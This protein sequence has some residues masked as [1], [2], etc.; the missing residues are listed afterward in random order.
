MSFK[1]RIFALSEALIICFYVMFLRSFYNEG[2]KIIEIPYFI[3]S[4]ACILYAVFAKDVYTIKYA[5][6]FIFGIAI[7]PF[8]YYVPVIWKDIFKKRFSSLFFLLGGSL[9][10]IFSALM[11]FLNFNNP[12]L[13]II[14]ATVLALSF[15]F[16]ILVHYVFTYHELLESK[17]IL[18]SKAL[19]NNLIVDEKNV[20]Y[21][22]VDNKLQALEEMLLNTRKMC[23]SVQNSLTDN[24]YGTAAGLKYD[25]KTRSL[26]YASGDKLVIESIGTNALR[27]III[28][29]PGDEITSAMCN[30]IYEKEIGKTSKIKSPSKVLDKLNKAFSGYGISTLFSLI[31]ADIFPDEKL[32]KYSGAG[33]PDILVIRDGNALELSTDG[34]PIGLDDERYQESEFVLTA[35]DEVI[36]YTDG[37]MHQARKEKNMP[38][39]SYISGTDALGIYNSLVEFAAQEDEKILDDILILKVDI[40]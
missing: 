40:L 13:N 2:A 15:S 37:I 5:E 10:F 20:V 21:F 17:Y 11:F 7:A 14:P 18:E 31:V 22:E 39:K 29:Y 8:S 30:L 33:F 26:K 24:N 27:F 1:I 4:G 23:A 25:I 3:L 6:I 12:Y 9:G 28:D 16:A 35:G 38:F 19:M 36:I 34:G 32:I